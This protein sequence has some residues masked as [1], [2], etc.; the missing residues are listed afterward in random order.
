MNDVKVAEVYLD[1]ANN[2]KKN[3]HK[4]S[5]SFSEFKRVISRKTCYYTSIPFIL[6]DKEYRKTID[7]VDN[8]K[9]Y[10][11]GNVVVCL[12][13]VNNIKSALENPTNQLTVHH[14]K[15]MCDKIIK[16]GYNV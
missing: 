14:L 10:V 9:G 8:S 16:G 12:N 3:G 4:F 1:K 7:R 13:V 11:S 15:K 2:A 6:E 5:L